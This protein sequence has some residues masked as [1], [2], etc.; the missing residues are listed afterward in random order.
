MLKRC[1]LLTIAMLGACL[2]QAD[3]LIV[4][5]DSNYPPYEF[6]DEDGQPDGFNVEMMRA[7]AEVMGLEI[8]ISLGPWL[9]VRSALE[10][11]EIDILTGMYYSETRDLSVDFSSPHIVVSHSVFVRRGSRFNEFRD[12]RN[13]EIIVQQGD[14]MHDFAKQNNIF[15]RIITVENQADALRLLASGQHDAALLAKLQGLYTVRQLKLNNLETTGPPI[16][17]R[18]YCFAVREGDQALLIK[19]NEGLSILTA[20]GRYEEIYQKWFGLNEREE[21]MRKLISYGLK[22][23]VPLLILLLLAFGWSWTLERRI[24]QKTA[25]LKESQRKL[26]TL[27][28]NLPGMAYRCK[29]DPGW[30]MLFISDGCFEIT[31]YRASELI[32]GSSISYGELIHPEDRNLVWDN[33]Q[34]A[35]SKNEPY[36][37][38]YRI[39]NRDGGIHWVWEKGRAISDEDGNIL[40]LEGFATDITER[41]QMEEMMI[42]S[43]KML[44]VGGLAAG[45][46]HE[47]NNPLAGI[48]QNLQVINNRIRPDNEKNRQIAQECNISIDDLYCYLERRGLL[49]MFDNIASSSQRAAQIVGNMLAFSR[50][51]DGN[52]RHENLARLLDTTIDLAANEYDLKKHYDFKKI[53]IIRN[54]QELPAV[55]CQAGKIQQVILNLLKNAAQ[56][57]TEAGTPDPQ[58]RIRLDRDADMALITVEDNGPGM[59]EEIRQRIFE[60]FFTTKENGVGTGLGLSISYFIITEDHKGSMQVESQPGQGTRFSISLPSRE[61][62]ADE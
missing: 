15:S 59:S 42:Q 7:V 8:E 13:T 41:K 29:N 18:K 55:S 12:L 26:K 45:M 25:S 62:G 20:S 1:L 56:A 37:L 11:G 2:L 54:Y 57:M 43:E 52:L 30:S 47:I 27:M 19:L 46:A 14:I 60:P 58:I 28:A 61:D 39:R 35:L 53:K 36:T 24:K 23:I 16:E 3:P 6:L 21:L 38:S 10:N 51:S 48:L 5:G 33:I 34:L 50:K 17:P 9:E 22:T 31:G 49:S 32:E 44:S 40:A 4:R